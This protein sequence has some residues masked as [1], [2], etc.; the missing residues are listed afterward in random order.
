M[1][2][3]T[4]LGAGWL[5]KPLALHLQTQG[6]TVFASK[7]TSQGIEE[8]E[9]LGLNGFVFKLLPSDDTLKA[10]LNEQKSDVLIVAFPPGIRSESKGQD[11]AEKWRCLAEQVKQTNVKKIVMVSSTSVYPSIAQTCLEEDASLTLSQKSDLFSDGSKQ[12][13]KAEQH[14]I[15]SGIRYGIVRCSGLMGPNR[16]PACFVRY[17][18]VVSQSAP[19]NM[20]H[21]DDAIGTIDYVAQLEQDIVVNATTPSSVTKDVF[22]KHAI[23]SAGTDYQLPS[24]IDSPDKKISAQKLL[25]LGYRFKYNHIIEALDAIPYT[26]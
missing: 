15:D 4:I 2:T 7:T 10:I 3:F 1:T 5:G 11:Y 13:L 22:Y 26:E 14:L 8:I 21:L 24:I 25:S 16:H 6:H 12:I 18:K 23:Q 9:Q 17:L 20:I 19:A